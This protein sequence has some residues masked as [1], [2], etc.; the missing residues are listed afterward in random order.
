MNQRRW[1]KGTIFV[2]A[3]AGPGRSPVRSKQSPLGPLVSLLE[4]ENEE[5]GEYISGSPR[6]ALEVMHPFDEYVFIEMA[7]DRIAE[8]EALR[9]EFVDRR[10]ID[11]RRGD[12]NEHLEDLLKGHLG[13]PGWK[14]VVFLDPFGMHVPWSTIQR[15][16]ATQNIEVF[17][18][19][20]LGMAVQRLLR[21]DAE[22]TPGC[23]DALDV[24]FG[25]TDWW[26]EVYTET[27][28][29]LGSR[30]VKRA[31]AGD[32]LLEFYRARLKSAFGLVSPGKLVRNTT[33][34]HLYYLI[35]AGT[36]P[37]G[38]MG[39]AYILGEQPKQPKRAK[40]A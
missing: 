30:I 35:W 20:T 12:A 39:A 2:D 40:S 18:N 11:I 17:I 32:R 14:A 10:K 8:L 26:A 28:D 31:D 38:L 13:K 25:T 7:N 15:L 24:F 29:L 9:S 21:K 6:R 16:G 5:E 36:H 37:K 4:P 19:F 3:F 34:A 33:G 23:R 1:L 27:H 22:I